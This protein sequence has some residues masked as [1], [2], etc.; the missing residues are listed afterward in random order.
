MRAIIIY[1]LL[2]LV[3]LSTK[4]QEVDEQTARKVA[5]NYFD[6]NVHDTIKA[7]YRSDMRKAAGTKL[8]VKSSRLKTFNDK[9]SYYINNLEG[10]GWVLV[11]ADKKTGPVIA[12]SEFGHYEPDSL[13]EVMIDWMAQYDTAISKRSLITVDSIIK[14]KKNKWNKFEN[15]SKFQ[16]KSES[17]SEIGPLLT[18]AWH[19]KWPFNSKVTF[20]DPTLGTC[21]AGCVAIAVSQIVNYW[22]YSQGYNANF[23]FWKMPDYPNN[24]SQRD[25]TA[26]MIEKIGHEFLQS[27]YCKSCDYCPSCSTRGCTTSAWDVSPWWLSDPDCITTLGALN[28]SG[29]NLDYHSCF[30]YSYD[31]WVDLLKDELDQGRPIIYSYIDKHAFICDG[32]KDLHKF[33]FNMGMGSNWLIWS[34]Y[35]DLSNV[36]GNDFSDSDNHRC[37][38]GIKPG[39]EDENTLNN[40]ISTNMSNNTW[41]YKMYLNAQNVTLLSGSINQMVAGNYI[42]LQPGF[43]AKPGSNF[44]A[45]TFLKPSLGGKSTTKAIVDVY[46]K[47]VNTLLNNSQNNKFLSYN[48]YPNPS[49]GLIYLDLLNYMNTDTISYSLFDIT[50]TFIR[51]CIVK[52]D[53]SIIDMNKLPKG[54]YI[55]R[56]YIN[57]NLFFRKVIKI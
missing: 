20:T 49:S 15:E 22:G 52:N 51:K 41:Q 30:Y 40:I 24:Q 18:T 21:P 7:K 10:G 19:Q 25:A 56:L 46:D 14:E 38:S 57:Q 23:E 27:I 43:W 11:S 44:V 54:I 26:Y 37:I 36:D 34:D 12:Y 6:R 45:K 29:A 48:L 32:Y 17:S 9:P 5:E 39:I 35:E 55:V 47:D 28:Y 53:R 4:A 13:P 31:E 2:C 8:S 3:T 42:T 1:F 50:G 33:H 16:V